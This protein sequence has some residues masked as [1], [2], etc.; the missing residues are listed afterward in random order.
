M[1]K[2]LRAHGINV[3]ASSELLELEQDSTG[4]IA[5]VRNGAGG[6]LH[7]RA[8][9]VVGADGAKGKNSSIILMIWRLKTI[10]RHHSQAGWNTVHWRIQ[11]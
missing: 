9:Y 11:A 8:K 10:K 6:K 3:E 5:V 7:I 1:R 2:H 4:V